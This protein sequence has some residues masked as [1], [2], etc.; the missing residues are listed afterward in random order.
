[1]FS[2]HLHGKNGPEMVPLLQKNAKDVGQKPFFKPLRLKKDLG[3]AETQVQSVICK[4]Y[5]CVYLCR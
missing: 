4:L 3:Y 1:M 2:E 5:I